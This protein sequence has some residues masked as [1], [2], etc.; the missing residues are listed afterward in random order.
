MATIFSSQNTVKYNF[1]LIDVFH[2]S[3]WDTM[4]I[5]SCITVDDKMAY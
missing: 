1:E 5:M 4:G 2:V 3:A